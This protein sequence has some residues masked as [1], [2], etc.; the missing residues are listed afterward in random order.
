M[1]VLLESIHP[2]AVEVLEA[3][4]D[5]MLVADPPYL[6][7]DLDSGQ[8]RALLTRGR[9]IVDAATFARLPQLVVAGRCG[10]GLDNIDL[11][12]AAESGVGVVHAPGSTTAAVAEHAVMLMLG[13]ARRLTSLSSS[14]RS[15]HWEHRDGYEGYELRGKRLGVI[16]MGAIGSR[17]AALG[18]AFDMDVVC[19]VQSDRAVP[20]PKVSLGELMR[21]SDVIQVCT[22]LTPETN[23][24]IGAAELA[25]AKPGLLMINTA[26]AAIIED[27]ALREALTTGTLGGYASDVWVI[28]PPGADQLILDERVLVTPHVAALTDVTY[29]EICVR[30]ADAV[31]ALLTGGEAD[32]AC[33]RVPL[34]NPEE[35]S[36]EDA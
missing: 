34:V 24:M 27:A 3:I 8:V 32:P 30:T 33:V 16:G 23:A 14:V 22:S 7:D 35:S 10:A 25:S 20:V 12:A 26:R 9:G 13:L 11:D 21:T 5:V 18:Q 29:R 19:S 15:G 1:I 6:D 36:H 31:S 4:D 17:V 28:E 2:D